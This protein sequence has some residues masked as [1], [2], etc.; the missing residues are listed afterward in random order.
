MKVTEIKPDPDNPNELTEEQ[1]FGLEKSIETYGTLQPLIIDQNNQIVDGHHRLQCF[2]NQG[3]TEVPCIKMNFESDSKRR[4]LRQAMNRLHG[5]H[6]P[7]KDIKELELILKDDADLL[8][9]LVNIS[10]E[11]VEDMRKTL[12]GAEPHFQMPKDDFEP[13][14]TEEKQV[15]HIP[16]SD[17]LLSK[18]KF[19]M[20]KKDINDYEELLEWFTSQVEVN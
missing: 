11:D 6:D 8:Q 19:I 7:E 3:Y 1:M 13:S 14:E 16:V 17:G 20:K 5:V 10:K 4:A 15:L 2:V 18:I 12:E 9:D